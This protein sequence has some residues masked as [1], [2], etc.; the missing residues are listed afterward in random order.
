MTQG[1]LEN[2]IDRKRRVSG[3]ETSMAKARG[4]NCA[5][6]LW[7]LEFSG[8]FPAAAVGEHGRTADQACSLLLAAAGG[9]PSDVAPV[10]KHAA[11]DGGF[12]AAS[13][14]G[15]AATAIW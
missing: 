11:A 2:G 4:M 1:I 15:A 5:W 14:V 3:N 10:R 12:A 7:L 8:Y 6:S 13:R 9:E